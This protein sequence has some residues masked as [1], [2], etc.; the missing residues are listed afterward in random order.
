MFEEHFIPFIFNGNIPRNENFKT[1][2]KNRRKCV[3]SSATQK[4]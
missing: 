4:G 3:I 1:D 2:K